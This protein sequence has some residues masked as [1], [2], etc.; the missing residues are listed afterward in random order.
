MQQT[1]VP[2]MHTIVRSSG[3]GSS[4]PNRVLA[5][6]VPRRFFSRF[7]YFPLRDI[8]SYKLRGRTF[9]PHRVDEDRYR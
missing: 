3:I 7:A 2:R 8:S 5:T 4:G 6:A 1:G 9:G